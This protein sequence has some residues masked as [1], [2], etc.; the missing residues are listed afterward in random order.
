MQTFWLSASFSFL[1]VHRGSS[2]DDRVFTFLLYYNLTFPDF[3]QQVSLS[4]LYSHIQESKMAS[5]WQKQCAATDSAYFEGHICS[6]RQENTCPPDHSNKITTFVEIVIWSKLAS[7]NFRYFISCIY[8]IN[9]PHTVVKLTLFTSFVNIASAIN[10]WTIPC[11]FGL[12]LRNH[13]REISWKSVIFLNFYLL[14]LR[15][16]GSMV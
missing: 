14:C 16:Q 13:I 15:M 8:K 2:P 4:F 11:A 6:Q 9:K 5:L 3:C 12:G 1:A 7:F 10:W